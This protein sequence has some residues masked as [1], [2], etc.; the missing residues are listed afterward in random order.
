MDLIPARP[1][2]VVAGSAE[3]AALLEE[4]W[5]NL[6][7]YRDE[8]VRKNLGWYEEMFKALEGKPSGASHDSNLYRTADGRVWNRRIDDVVEE[9]ARGPAS[10]WAP[11]DRTG[12]R[13]TLEEF[14]A[15]GPAERSSDHPEDAWGWEHPPRYGYSM[16]NYLRVGY[17]R[18]L[19]AIAWVDAM[20]TRRAEVDAW[21][22]A[23][24]LTRSVDSYMTDTAA[25]FETWF[26]GD[27]QN[28]PDTGSISATASSVL[29]RM[30]GLGRLRSYCY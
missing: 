19:A 3:E 1:V 25:F 27:R 24:A 14:K 21:L 18:K 12:V 4:W 5:T 6:V 22:R 26:V 17:D 29:D 28:L 20:V 23:R 7:R 15:L 11:Y 13:I 9:L 8:F 2:P 16:E 10:P 30:S